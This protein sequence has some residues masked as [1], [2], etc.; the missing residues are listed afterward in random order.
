M[1]EFQTVWSWQPALY[2]FLGGMGAGALIASSAL[3]FID[4]DRHKR[5]ILCSLGASAICMIIGLLLLLAELVLPLRGMMLWQSFV[6]PSSWMTYGAWGVLLAVVV[7]V[8]TAA[9]LLASITKIFGKPLKGAF[10]INGKGMSFLFI[11]GAALGLFVAVYTGLLLMSAPGV[12]LWGTG[13]LPVLFTVSAMGTGVAL[14]ELVSFALRKRETMSGQ[15]RM[16]FEKATI[17]LVLIEACVLTVFLFVMASG[18]GAPEGSMLFASVEASVAAIT[19]GFLA[20]FFWCLVVGC[21]LVAPLVVSILCLRMEG[22]DVSTLIFTGACGT[23]IGGCAL[24]FI[25]LL[26]GTH[27]NY[28]ADAIASLI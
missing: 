6:N 16:F 28:V 8:V 25:V 1:V 18:N 4:R 23:L 27:A 19:T 2:L 17:V 7:A 20:P 21:G 5:T 15:S 3:A 10:S 14:V 9:L 11:L 26:A 13:L 24:R 12:P 22:R